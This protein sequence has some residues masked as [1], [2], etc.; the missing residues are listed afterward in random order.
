M[1]TLACAPFDGT[2]DSANIQNPLRGVQSGDLIVGGLQ[3]D[4]DDTVVIATEFNAD[5]E[6][7]MLDTGGGSVVTMAAGE[8]PISP[9]AALG[10]KAYTVPDA[11]LVFV[12]PE[13]GRHVRADG[14]I[15]LTVATG[16]QVLVWV[17]RLPA[18]FVGVGH[19]NRASIP[20]APA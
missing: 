18:G 1:A 17:Y 20:A 10:A 14:S 16:G 6:I 3:L 19:M 12:V 13:A 4:D 11:D 9:R 2:T 15:R 8:Y 7:F 5:L